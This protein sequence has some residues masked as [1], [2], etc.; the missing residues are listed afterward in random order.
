MGFQ[1]SSIH[2]GAVTTFY[3]T[4]KWTIFCMRFLVI[5]KAG[6]VIKSLSTLLIKAL[7]ELATNF[8]H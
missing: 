5:E 1:M 2:K 4:F 3:V 8:I 7:E 6:Q